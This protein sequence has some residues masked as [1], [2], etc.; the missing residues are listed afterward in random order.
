MTPT[1]R[2][3]EWDGYEWNMS[4]SPWDDEEIIDDHLYGDDS[5][6]EIGLTRCKDFILRLVDIVLFWR[7]AA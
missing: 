5:Y 6:V 3:W 2:K 4:Y 1:D 7:K